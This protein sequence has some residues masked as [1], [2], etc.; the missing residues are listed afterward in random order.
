MKIDENSPSNLNN[1]EILQSNPE[2]LGEE[3]STTEEIPQNDSEELTEGVS[4]AETCESDQSVTAP[5]VQKLP[6][7][8]WLPY[9]ITFVALAAVTLLV[10]WAEGGYNGAPTWMALGQWGSSIA[11]AGMFGVSVG[12]LVWAS[13]GGAFDIFAY[14]GR[15]FARMFFKKDVIDRKYRTY[16]DYRESRKDKKRSFW[17][18][19]IVGGGYLLLGVILL[20][21]SN[22]L[23]PV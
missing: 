9:V 19:M 12:I 7:R 1:G 6:S 14:G 3:V 13:N 11:I 22:Q 10:A 20:V 8:P 23:K 2:E 5:N 17:Y 18:M 4:T 16:Y 21:V 15:V